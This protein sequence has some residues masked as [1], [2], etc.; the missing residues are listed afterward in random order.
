MLESRPELFGER[1][2]PLTGYQIDNLLAG[3]TRGVCATGHWPREPIT[4]SGF[5]GKKPAPR[6][7]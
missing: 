1:T 4:R 3:T 6:R 2:A 5:P 7:A